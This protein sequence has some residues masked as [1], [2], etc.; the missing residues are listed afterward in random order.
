MHML[1][2]RLLALSEQGMKLLGFSAVDSVNRSALGKSK[3]AG[4]TY[5]G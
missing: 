4:L 5:I 2:D 3:S 1:P